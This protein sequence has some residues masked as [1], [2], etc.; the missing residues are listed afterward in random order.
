MAIELEVVLNDKDSFEKFKNAVSEGVLILK[1]IDGLKESLKTIGQVLKNELDV[2]TK[3]FNS[4]VKHVYKD[5]IDE[6]L[7]YLSTIEFAISKI[8][9]DEADEYED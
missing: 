6:E 3:D 9:D 8:K 7:E 4:V 5:E 2:A 1:Q